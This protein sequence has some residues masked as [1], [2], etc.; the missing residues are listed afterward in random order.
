[1]DSTILLDRSYPAENVGDDPAATVRDGNAQKLTGNTT[2]HNR[3]NTRKGL[4]PIQHNVPQDS[5]AQ[6]KTLDEATKPTDS[7]GWTAENMGHRLAITM[8]D[9]RK[10]REGETKTHNTHTVYGDGPESTLPP[11]VIHDYRTQEKN[12]GE[13]ITSDNRPD[14][15]AGVWF[16]IEKTRQQSRLRRPPQGMLEQEQ[17]PN[18]VENS[19]SSEGI[20]CHKCKK[21][22]DN[23][24]G[25]CSDQ[26]CQHTYCARCHNP[27]TW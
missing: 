23:G 21:C 1:M 26:F 2:T 7:F 10:N 8:Q 4:P 27:G 25:V 11:A 12:H 24:G 20:T 3:Y 18:H 19:V 13:G 5:Q 9:D 17:S 16:H 15:M 14:S 22:N 6:A